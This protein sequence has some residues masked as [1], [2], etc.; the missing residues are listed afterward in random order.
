MDWL[1]NSGYT[2]RAIHQVS[3]EATMIRLQ[4]HE[5]ITKSQIREKADDFAANFKRSLDWV[6]RRRENTI[7]CVPLEAKYPLIGSQSAECISSMNHPRRERLEN[8]SS[9]AFLQ[10]TVVLSFP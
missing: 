4:R 6:K 9:V 2:A 1:L 7:K 10:E 5:S 3:Q 8:R